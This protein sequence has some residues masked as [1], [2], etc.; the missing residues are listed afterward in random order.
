ME[1]FLVAIWTI[2]KI[3]TIE[4]FWTIKIFW[5][6]KGCIKKYITQVWWSLR[7]PT[8]RQHCRLS[9]CCYFGW[10]LQIWDEQACLNLGEIAFPKD[11]D[12]FVWFPDNW[13]KTWVCCRTYSFPRSHLSIHDRWWGDSALNW[14]SLDWA[15]HH[16]MDCPTFIPPTF[17][18][19][20]IHQP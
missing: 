16:W 5:Q 2:K 19:S 17:I 7:A 9:I 4:R 11:G 10:V 8:S 13:L 20:D 6:W 18:T 1:T 15:A 3:W 12:R 14:D